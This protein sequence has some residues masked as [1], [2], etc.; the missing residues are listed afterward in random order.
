MRPHR[1]NESRRFSAIAA[2]EKIISSLEWE[3]VLQNEELKLRII[4]TLELKMR[5]DMSNQVQDA[6]CALLLVVDRER[7]PSITK[8]DRSEL[9]GDAYNSPYDDHRTTRTMPTLHQRAV[10]RKHLEGYERAEDTRG[11][12]SALTASYSS[13]STAAAALSQSYSAATSQ[14]MPT[15]SNS[16]WSQSTQA[17]L[18]TTAR[19]ATSATAESGINESA[20]LG[21]STQPSH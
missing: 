10:A 2:L 12:L 6:A 20:A 14:S 9:N 19:V 13:V 21:N 8:R 1:G 18:S 7:R 16:F 11:L 15:N 17:Q 4:H 5:F 3:N